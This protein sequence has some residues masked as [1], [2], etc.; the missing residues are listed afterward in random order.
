[1]QKFYPSFQLSLENH[2]CNIYEVIFMK[3][4]A[5][6]YICTGKYIMFWKDFYESMESKFCINSNVEYFV[7]TDAEKIY[8]EDTTGKIH[9]I[10]QENLGWPNNTLKRFE[11]F[12]KA[13]RQLENFDYLF[14]MNANNLITTSIF[15][16]DFL[17]DKEDLLFVQHPG[18]YNKSSAKFTYERNKKST[19]YVERCNGKYYICGGLNGGKTEA[20]LKLARTL[21]NNIEIDEKNKI[22][23]RWHDESHINNYATKTTNYRLL[24][25]AFWYPEDW[26][27]PF[28]KKI[29][30]RNKNKYFDVDKGK[31]S[32]GERI[33]RKITGNFFL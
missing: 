29:I 25:P 9:K 16:S 8:A 26:N 23:A 22:V 4:I 2:P 5:I 19:A 12:L 1:M 3:N 28:E 15:E 6:L 14:F 33:M 17:P 31:Y 32:I 13:E 27:L 18:F 10:F 24:S 11:I 7:F 20:F 21:K 30:V